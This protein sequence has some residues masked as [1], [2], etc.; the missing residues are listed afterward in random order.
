MPPL[1][2]IVIPTRNSAQILRRCLESVKNQ[3]YRNIETI[4][5]DNYSTDATLEIAK[6][7]G[8]IVLS[9]GP[10]RSAQMNFGILNSSG[11]Y[12]YRL[13]SDMIS[14]PCVV[15]EAV[16]TCE[17]N[18][19]DGII[20]RVV[21][22]PTVSFWSEVRSFERKN[23]YFYDSNVAVRFFSR[24]AFDSINGFNETLNGFEDY[25]FH[26]RF[27]AAGY[28]FGRISSTEVHLGEPR[29]L[30]EIIRK[31]AYYGKDLRRYL[32]NKKGRTKQSALRLS[33]IRLGQTNLLSELLR[34]PNILLGLVF[35][36]TARYFAT[37]IGML[38]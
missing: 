10:E 26:D 37:V 27:V 12:V 3:T 14:G 7:Y 6:D 22:D 36:Q 30:A 16:K 21:S 15:E 33:M 8:T 18:S 25:E 24:K 38:S 32:A 35:Y 2:S 34:Q 19:I 13:D 4:V 17:L 20:I 5:V 23:L 1:V 31:H 9:K 11:K 29:T 28:R